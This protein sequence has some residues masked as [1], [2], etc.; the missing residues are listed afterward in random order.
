MPSVDGSVFGLCQ[1]FPFTPSLRALIPRTTLRLYLPQS[2]QQVPTWWCSWWD[3]CGICEWRS[4]IRHCNEIPCIDLNEQT[5]SVCPFRH[6]LLSFSHGIIVSTLEKITVFPSSIIRENGLT[7]LLN[8]LGFVSIAAQ[9]TALQAASNCY[10][11]ITPE[12]FQMI[13][14]VWPIIRKCLGYSDLR[15]VEFACPCFI[16]I[17]TSYYRSVFRES[18]DPR[19]R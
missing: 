19:G 2:C 12:H 1:A 11:N 17:I 18:Q 3:G 7:A 10:Q 14:G 5:M 4:C 16:Y 15:L 13:R 8:Y 6:L 9:H